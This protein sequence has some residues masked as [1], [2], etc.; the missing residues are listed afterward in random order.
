M[1]QKGV[2]GHPISHPITSECPSPPIYPQWDAQLGYIVVVQD[3]LMHKIHVLLESGRS[4][5]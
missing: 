3:N 1:R 2:L 4:L 5:A